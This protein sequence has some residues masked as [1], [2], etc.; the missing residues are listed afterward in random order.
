MCYTHV[1][2]DVYFKAY[3]YVFTHVCN[4]VYIYIALH[5]YV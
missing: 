2:C 4:T 5:M 1:L 3:Q